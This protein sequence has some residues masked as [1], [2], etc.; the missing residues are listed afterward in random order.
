MFDLIFMKQWPRHR[1]ISSA[2]LITFYMAAGA[3]QESVA[4]AGLA[5]DWCRGHIQ[6]NK[7]DDEKG[8]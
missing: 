6:C 5:L 7:L 3:S 1:P 8:T 2:G 4:P